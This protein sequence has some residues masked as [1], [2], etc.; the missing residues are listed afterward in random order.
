MYEDVDKFPLMQA[1]DP[2]VEK[3]YESTEEGKKVTR[4]KG[5]K[6]LAVYRRIA[7][8]YVATSS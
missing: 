7:D 4:N 3:L 8:P 2:I 5:D 1:A 6:Y